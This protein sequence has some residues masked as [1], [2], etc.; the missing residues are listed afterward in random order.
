MRCA[1]RASN[2]GP[3]MT[4]EARARYMGMRSFTNMGPDFRQLFAAVSERWTPASLTLN[5][6]GPWNPMEDGYQVSQHTFNQDRKD[7]FSSQYHYTMGGPSDI[8]I[9]FSWAGLSLS[10]TVEIPSWPNTADLLAHFAAAF[11]NLREVP[12]SAGMRVR[13]L[14][15]VFGGQTLRGVGHAWPSPIARQIPVDLWHQLLRD[16]GDALPAVTDALLK[17]GSPAGEYFALGLQ[18]GELTA[19]REELVARVT[20]AAAASGMESKERT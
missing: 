7:A 1:L 19:A 17:V 14:T 9:A 5:D 13:S 18:L 20:A 3:E 12:P 6:V 10:A 8:Q 2:G 4:P 15:G 11:D 16:G